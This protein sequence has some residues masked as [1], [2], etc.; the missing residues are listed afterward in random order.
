MDLARLV[1]FLERRNLIC[2]D[3]LRLGHGGLL[4][5]RP[6]SIDIGERFQE[7]AGLLQALVCVFKLLCVDL[8]VRDGCLELVDKSVKGLR[9]VLLLVRGGSDWKY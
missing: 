2:D 7:C 5:R 9:V 4:L 6:V 8:D 3:G 1:N